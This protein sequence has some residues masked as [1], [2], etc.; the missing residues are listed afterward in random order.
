MSGG[1]EHGGRGHLFLSLPSVLHTHSLWVIYWGI[2]NVVSFSGC[3]WFLGLYDCLGGLFLLLFICW[4]VRWV[5]RVGC[6]FLWLSCGSWGCTFV[7]VVYFCLCL[8]VGLLGL[9]VHRVGCLFLW[10]S[11]GSWGCTC[12]L[13]VYFC[14]CLFAGLLGLGVH[15][16]G[17]SI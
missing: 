9:W 3:L 13:V 17:C 14:L 5:H 6:L 15:S 8:F 2:T 1:R 12:V 10:L 16:V 7:L 11:C 4:I